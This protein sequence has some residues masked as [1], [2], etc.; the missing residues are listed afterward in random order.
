ML[1][2]AFVEDEEVSIRPILRLIAEKEPDVQV[3]ELDFG[4]AVDGIRSL[5]P[6]IVVLDLWEGEA[7]DNKN[8]G[9]EHLN[10]IW[11][12]QFCPVIIHSAN[13]DIPPEQKNSFVR[14]VT[15]GQYS[16]QE[17][18]NAIREFRP[19]VEALKETE[20]DIRDRYSIAMRDVAP[21]TFDIF[22][23]DDKR[24]DAIRRAGRRRLAALMDETSAK[25]HDLKS[26][27]Q[28]LCPPVSKDVLAGDVLRKADGDETDASSFRVVLT[29]SCD[30][31]SGGGGK[32]KVGKVLVAKC[33]PT[34]EGFDLTSLSGVAASKL[35]DR[36]I[37]SVLSRGY[38]ETILPMPALQDRIPTMVADL[39]DLEL[40]PLCDIG[41]ECKPFL[42]IASLDSPFRE[43]IS[44]A[45]VQ[46][47]GRPGLPDRVFD[48]W[49]DE[50][51]A[52]YES[53]S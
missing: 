30:L 4:A 21:S 46:V 38:F 37:G 8:R 7:S 12:Q 22:A 45:Y 32:A 48:E 41:A 10:F 53:E 26:W 36:L 52:A 28:Y 47:A 14:E 49:R 29:P 18:L 17:V 24:R 51:I 13:P 40:I 3:C 15:K 6:D 31:A 39:R 19:H 1:K 20:R 11:E 5:R 50:V 27:E 2:I 23:S 44:W 43:L 34:R 9:S 42:R 35:K 25:G 33:C 16:P